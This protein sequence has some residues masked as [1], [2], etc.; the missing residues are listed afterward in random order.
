V[1][2]GNGHR[3]PQE[4]KKRP[5]AGKRGGARSS[6]T[7]LGPAGARLPGTRRWLPP[8]PRDL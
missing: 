7:G 3:V 4:R 5:V 1:A 6:E 8:R 2:P